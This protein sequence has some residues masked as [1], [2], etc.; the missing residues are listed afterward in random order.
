VCS[1]LPRGWVP[2]SSA[3]ASLGTPHHHHKLPRT[4]SHIF[5]RGCIRKEI[6]RAARTKSAALPV[7]AAKRGVGPPSPFSS[8]L[9]PAFGGSM[10][11]TRLAR[12]RQ[13][14]ARVG[15]TR[16]LPLTQA[17]SGP[18]KASHVA[19]QLVAILQT[20]S[21]CLMNWQGGHSMASNYSPPSIKCYT[22]K[23]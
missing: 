18:A 1:V 12:H 7:L 21:S 17:R 6:S 20:L 13:R 22:Y 5:L 23:R 19:P 4:E 3:G 14:R 2:M 15:P 9:S 11:P 10:G 8:F 16:G